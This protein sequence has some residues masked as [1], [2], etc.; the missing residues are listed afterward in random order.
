MLRIISE[1][2]D[3]GSGFIYKKF[4]GESGIGITKYNELIKKLK[5]K[6]LIKA[7]YVKGKRGRCRDITA[8]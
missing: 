3:H 1:S 6:K 2:S 8:V 4:R 5:H 7:E